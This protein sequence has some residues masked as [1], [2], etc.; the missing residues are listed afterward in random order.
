MSGKDYYAILGVA[1]NAGTEELKKAYRKL[2][3]K[4]HPD[5]N[6]G[7]KV[8]E[9]KFKEINEAY[10]VLSDSEKRKQ[11][12]TF[13][14]E[15]FGQRFSRDDIFRGFDFSDLFGGG[16]GRSRG[17]FRTTTMGGGGIEDMISQLF[18]MSGMGGRGG[19]GPGAGMGGA[20]Q[21]G[22]DVEQSV[23]IP[24]MDAVKGSTLNLKI[25]DQSGNW[26][27][28]SVR[29]PPGVASG[30][31]LR[32]RSKGG[33]SPWGG[34]RGDLFLVVKVDDDPLFTRSGD[35]LYCDVL[36][37][38]SVMV[39]GGTAEVTVL[40]GTK[41]V[42]VNPGTQ[43]GTRIRLKGHGVPIKGGGAG[44]LFARVMPLFPAKVSARAKEL[45]KELAAEGW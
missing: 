36:V 27:S 7:D 21:R 6:K 3:M 9:D 16:G 4:Y 35:D 40:D 17:G 29:I 25:P 30:C 14:A 41:K 37:P 43:P 23:N 33:A 38:V 42:K 8:A 18:G 26:E 13:G 11:Y 39:N 10:A 1:R 12:D 2:A 19:S 15:G 22:Q 32:V 28:V 45:F 44:D 31:R 20:H 24:F 34:Q 5:R